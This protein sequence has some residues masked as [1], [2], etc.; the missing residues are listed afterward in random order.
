M[1]Y[2]K[3]NYIGRNID[4]FIQNVLISATEAVINGTEIPKSEDSAT[5]VLIYLAV[6]AAQGGR[7]DELTEKIAEGYKAGLSSDSMIAVPL[8]TAPY[9]GFPRTLNMRNALSAA[10]DTSKETNEETK[11]TITM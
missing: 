9:N 8:L 5:Q 3:E 11:T 1:N 10:L 4:D 6:M 7:E 2:E